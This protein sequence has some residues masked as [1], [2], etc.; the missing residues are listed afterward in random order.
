MP[1]TEYQFAD[2]NGTKRSYYHYVN[3]STMKNLL[4]EES[5]V[6]TIDFFDAKPISHITM[7]HT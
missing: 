1:V 2:T 3:G 6:E 7:I 4:S 5:A